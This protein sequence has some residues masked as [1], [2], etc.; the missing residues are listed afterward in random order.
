MAF[1]DDLGNPLG[2]RAPVEILGADQAGW[3]PQVMGLEPGG[4]DKEAGQVARF[5]M[6]S[7]SLWEIWFD[8]APQEEKR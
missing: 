7:D 4:T 3:Y 5:F 1:S 6:G 8:H 2:W